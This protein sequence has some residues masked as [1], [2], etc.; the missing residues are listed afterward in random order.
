V[1][2]A[3]LLLDAGADPNALNHENAT[4]LHVAVKEGRVELVRLLVERGADVNI[5][6]VSKQSPWSMAQSSPEIRAILETFGQ[7]LAQHKPTPDELVARLM[8][9]PGFKRSGLWPCSDK[10]IEQLEQAFDLTLPASYKKFLRLMGKGAGGFLISDHWEAFYPDLF[11]LGQSAEYQDACDDLPAQYFVFASRLGSVYLFFIAD[12][13]DDDPP[14][15][16]FGDDHDG[17]YKKIYDSFWGFIEDMVIY[18]EV[19]NKKGLV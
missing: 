12:G 17:G 7:D 4:P 11:E 13:A 5:R 3:R 14:V 2:I 8:A 10:E 1:E 15:Y 9:I 6:D 19:Y 18:Y 16:A